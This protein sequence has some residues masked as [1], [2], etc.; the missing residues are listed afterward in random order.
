MNRILP[1]AL[2]AVSG[3]F[4]ASL[5]LAQAPAPTP[6]AKAPA[7]PAAVRAATAAVATADEAEVKRLM[8]EKFPGVEVLNVTKSPFFGLYEVF[9][10]EQMAYTDAKVT[11][12]MV[13]T[14]IDPASRTNLTEERI[15]ALKAINVADLPLDQAIKIVRGKGERK[16]IVFSDA[17]CPFCKR[18]ENTLQDMDNVTAYVLLYPIDQLHPDAARKS[19]MIWCAPDRPKAWLDFM[20][21]GNLPANDGNCETPLPQLQ[22]LAQKYRVVATP[23]MVFMDGRVVPGALPKERL[24]KEFARADPAVKTALKN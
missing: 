13:G 19:K 6:A 22:A 8:Q 23:T 20:L 15:Q 18:L 1:L 17:D 24:E 5:T 11:Y 16:M 9:T 10:G 4:V 21:K 7:S 3:A 14:V 2:A 12:I